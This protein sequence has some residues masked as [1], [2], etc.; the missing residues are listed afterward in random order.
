VV[1]KRLLAIVLAIFLIAVYAFFGVDYLDQE[2][3][4]EVLTRGI[5]DAREALA[6]IAEL[7]KDT[8]ERLAT[9]Q[10][11][12]TAVQ[13]EFPTEIDTT[14]VVSTIL[15]L[16]EECG[17]KV[18]PLVTEAWSGNEVGGHEYPVFRVEIDVEGAFI[19]TMDFLSMLESTEFKTLILGDLN[20]SSIGEPLGERDLDGETSLMMTN[21]ELAV[22]VRPETYD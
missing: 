21:L 10:A 6:L 20:I 3:Q 2:A 5:S 15:R 7:P 4:K 11:G 19:D 12:L 16:G 18:L 22:Y 17:V 13:N 8:E 9:A 1:R 14:L